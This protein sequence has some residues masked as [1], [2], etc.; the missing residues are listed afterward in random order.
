MSAERLAERSAIQSALTD[1]DAQALK[2][3]VDRNAGV[4]LFLKLKDGCRPL[5]VAASQ[6][7]YECLSTLVSSLTVLSRSRAEDK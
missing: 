2:R 7:S 3:V 6:G 5:H 4:N 1:N